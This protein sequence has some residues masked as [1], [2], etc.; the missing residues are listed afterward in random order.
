MPFVT[1]CSVLHCTLQQ[2]HLLLPAP[3]ASPQTSRDIAVLSISTARPARALLQDRRSTPLDLA[4]FPL[5]VLKAFA[6]FYSNRFEGPC[7]CVGRRTTAESSKTAIS[8]RWGELM[9]SRASSDGAYPKYVSLPNAPLQVKVDSVRVSQGGR[10]LCGRQA[11]A[12]KGSLVDLADGRPTLLELPWLQPAARLLCPGADYCSVRF[13][14]PAS[15]T[16]ASST[17][18]WCCRC[19]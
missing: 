13:L 2:W 1:F 12:S 17:Q 16:C 19:T 11:L 4:A 3:D 6:C 10:R 5:E 18:I 15:C 7:G 14:Q 8:W 9:E